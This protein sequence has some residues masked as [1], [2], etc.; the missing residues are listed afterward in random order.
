M[1]PARSPPAMQK[2]YYRTFSLS[3]LGNGNN[4]KS[5]KIFFLLPRL[6]NRILPRLQFLG[7]ENLQA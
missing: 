4:V 5:L 2:N 7:P 6:G 3:A 1:R